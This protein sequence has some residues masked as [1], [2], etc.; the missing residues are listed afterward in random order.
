MR[1]L[2]QGINYA[3]ELTG[4]GKYTGEMAVQLAEQGH[5]VTVI[6]APP[7]YPDWKIRKD[8]KGKGWLVEYSN[9]VRIFR[10][11]LYVPRRVN[12]LKRILHE[13]SFLLATIPVWLQF[14]FGK[15]FDVV[16]SIAPPFHLGFLPLIYGK[17]RNVPVESHIQDL[18]ID[19]AKELGMIKNHKFL[20]LMFTLER[21]TLKHSSC[22]STISNGMMQHIWKK[23]VPNDKTTILPNWVD[24]EEIKPLPV[25]ESLRK[26]F[27]IPLQDKVVLYSGNLGE[28]QGLE[29][30][31]DVAAKFLE[32]ADVH[33]LIVG[34]GGTKLYLQKIAEER[35]LRN[36]H[37]YPLQPY[38]HLSALLASADVHLVL[39]KKSAA[40]LVM[41]SKLGGILSAGGCAIVTASPGTTL[42]DIVK[43]NN[44]GIIVEP[45]SATALTAAIKA[46]LDGSGT[47]NYKKNARIFAEQN[48]SK[49]QILRYLEIHLEKITTRDNAEVK[50]PQF[51]IG[52]A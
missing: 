26:K 20:N 42:Y 18:Q 45:E 25:E 21:F 32:S 33:F 7:Y 11:P 10:V 23:G 15:K 16:F 51:A 19:A 37:F 48:L 43:E 1:I 50:V 3:P 38:Q 31:M 2:I 13:F 52:H 6:T 34:S 14:T 40:D 12:A 35:D 9:G 49:N 39:Q 17:L 44:M 4:I 22:V 27:G 24:T 47:E 5:E 30:I 8:Y 36:V 29:I 46:A 28:K 41:P